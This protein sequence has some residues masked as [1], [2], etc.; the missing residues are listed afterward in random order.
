[1]IPCLLRHP[2]P[3]HGSYAMRDMIV[4]INWHLLAWMFQELFRQI[5]PAKPD[6]V[7]FTVTIPIPLLVLDLFFLEEVAGI[8]GSVIDA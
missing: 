4:F 5:L 7:N 2:I 6:G 1:M 8:Y 3:P